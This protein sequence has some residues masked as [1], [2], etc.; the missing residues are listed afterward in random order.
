MPA[1]SLVIPVTDLIDGRMFYLFS[2]AGS[3]FVSPWVDNNDEL[4]TN[5]SIY[6]GANY[7]LV[8]HPND[9]F[10]IFSHMRGAFVGIHPKSKF[11]T[12]ASTI[13]EDSTFF[14]MMDVG[15]GKFALKSLKST[16]Q[17]GPYISKQQNLDRFKVGAKNIGTL[18]HFRGYAEEI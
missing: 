14:S 4:W 12:V 10:K 16:Y 6:S 2:V 18:N 9:V 13:P 3:A 5:K 17:N 7:E 1:P 11:L 15:D 8:R